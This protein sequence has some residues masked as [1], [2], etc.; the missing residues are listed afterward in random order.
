MSDPNVPC[1][2]CEEARR[3]VQ[4]LATEESVRLCRRCGTVLE[5]DVEGD[6]CETCRL[7][8]KQFRQQP[9]WVTRWLYERVEKAEIEPT[10]VSCPRCQEPA[11]VTA[12]FCPHCGQR[13]VET[14]P[15]GPLPPA[16]E[17]SPPSPVEEP[18]QEAVALPPVPPVPARPVPPLRQQVGEFWQQVREVLTGVGGA[19]GPSWGQQIVGFFRFLFGSGGGLSVNEALLWVLVLLLVGI[20]LLGFF[21]V[22]M[23]RTNQI[24]FR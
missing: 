7:V 2:F 11:P 10:R 15:A 22:W 3:L 24:A 20:V 19:E 18:L 6:L 16:A 5:G 17:A 14:P 9:A 21:L 4:Q 13:L 8:Q 23:V 1:P 12:T